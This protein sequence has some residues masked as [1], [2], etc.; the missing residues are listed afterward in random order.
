MCSA[1]ATSCPV[2]VKRAHEKSRLSLMLGEKLDLRRTTPISS[3]ME[4]REFLRISNDIGSRFS[5]ARS[6]FEHC[7]AEL[8][9]R[10]Q[11]RAG[12]FARSKVLAQSRDLDH[13]SPDPQYGLS[14]ALR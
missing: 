3:A 6:D 11:L 5:M 7:L 2:A 4:M 13:H 8:I 1:W 9:W 14:N 12:N 10:F